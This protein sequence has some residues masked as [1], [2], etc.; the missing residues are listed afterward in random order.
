MNHKKNFILLLS[1]LTIRATA[2]QD[3]TSKTLDEVIVTANKFEQKQHETGKIVTVITREDLWKNS[4]QT[5]GQILDRQTGIIVNGNENALGTNQ[6]I[7]M[8]GASPGN[9]LILVDGIPLYDPS[10]ISSEFDIN[11]FNTNNIERIE[12]LKGAQSTLYGSDATAGV[13]NFITKK[14]GLKKIIGYGTVSGGSYGTINAAAGLQGNINNWKYSAGY[15]FL[16]TDGF[17]SA[18]DSTF[19]NNYDNDGFSKHS[20]V[21]S[22]G[23]DWN[24]KFS[25]R[26]FSLYNFY[27]PDIDAGAFV[28]DK[29]Y[30]LQNHNFQLGTELKYFFKNKRLRFHYA[31]NNVERTYTD[32]STHIPSFAIYQEG[33]YKGYSHFA[34]LYGNFF[35]GKNINLVAGVDYRYNFTK[36]HYLTI[37]NF[38]PYETNL[39]DSAKTSQESVYASLIVK[40]IPKVTLEAGGRLNHHSIYGTN[41]TYS[42]N[43]SYDFNENWKL[44][45]NIASAYRVPSLYQLYSEYGNKDLHPEETQNAEGGIQYKTVQTT[46]RL[47]AFTR[48]TKNIIVFFTDPLTYA[49]KYINGGTQYGKGFEAELNQLITN[50]ISLS[51][52]Y[53]FIDGEI[54]TNSDFTGKDTSYFNLYRRPQH[55]LNL[56]VIVQSIKKLTFSAGVKWASHSYE[57]AYLSVPIKL[58]GYYTVQANVVYA[59]KEK[60]ALFGDFN[61]ITNQKYTVIRGF[62]TKGFNCMGGIRIQF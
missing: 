58:N 13:I 4:S 25:L 54:K 33:N 57:P 37:S 3:S 48:K 5:I 27:D 22:I 9:T 60:I 15:S 20:L 32:D 23:K 56:Y 6:T 40:S 10:G 39:G 53:S 29:D 16:Q 61:N 26:I 1:L 45:L 42:F 47:S 7:Y 49:G 17:S 59:I 19:K 31:L 50:N 24:K 62:N 35:P 46:A 28:D 52:N 41:G 2:Q 36:Q 51:A 30:T 8:R 11:Y 38:G 34:E 12:I 18:T 43:P 55:V 44:F 21:A 14:S